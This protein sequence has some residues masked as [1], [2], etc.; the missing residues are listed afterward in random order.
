MNDNS[1]FSELSERSDVH[2]LSMILSEQWSLICS[3][4]AGGHTMTHSFSE[5][6]IHWVTHKEEGGGGGVQFHS[7]FH[8]CFYWK[9]SW[10]F[11]SI[12]WLSNTSHTEHRSDSMFHMFCR[13]ITYNLR[14]IFEAK[15]RTLHE[16]GLLML[17]RVCLHLKSTLKHLF[18]RLSVN[19]FWVLLASIL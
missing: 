5:S 18:Y 12:I 4:D 3:K 16:Q 11:L 10:Y 15:L 2:V 9:S 19:K 13:G 17:V 7:C 1:Y 8:R 14:Y 6:L